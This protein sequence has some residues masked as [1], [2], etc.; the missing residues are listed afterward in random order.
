MKVAT[1]VVGIISLIVLLV[2]L[3]T[4]PTWL[5]WNWLSPSVFGGPTI[6]LLQAMGIVAL[7]GILFKSSSSS[8][9]A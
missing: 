9:S 1:A 2:I 3:M 4:I 5:L 6:T 7:S 8:G